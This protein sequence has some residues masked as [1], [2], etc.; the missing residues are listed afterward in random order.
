MRL[1]LKVK[2]ADEVFDV[3]RRQR[4]ETRRMEM[5]AFV[6]TLRDTFTQEVSG[7]V[8]GVL[9]GMADVPEQVRERALAY[10]ERVG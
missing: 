2:P 5:D 7:D 9:A 8:A 6:S 1:R 10:L 3:E 4:V